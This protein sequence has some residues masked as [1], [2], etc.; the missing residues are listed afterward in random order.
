MLGKKTN[1][2]DKLYMITNKTV[3]LF[4]VMDQEQWFL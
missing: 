4:G 1:L 2:I 3:W